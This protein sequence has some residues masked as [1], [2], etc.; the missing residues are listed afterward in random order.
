MSAKPIIPADISS[1]AEDFLQRT[2]EVKHEERPDADELL[3]H[4]W[5]VNGPNSSNTNAKKS[6]AGKA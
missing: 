6:R 1:E 4:P 2:F 3:Q 5:I